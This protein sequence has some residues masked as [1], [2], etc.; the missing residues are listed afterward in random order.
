MCEH[1]HEAEAEN[2]KP[3]IIRI[4][5]AIIIFS[6]ALLYNPSGQSRFF[7]FFIAY[8]ISGGDIIL[9]AIKHIIKGKIFDENFLVNQE[10]LF[11]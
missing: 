8:L 2:N 7:L 5:L 11:L 10:K 3:K 6:I 4:I 9:S 1:H